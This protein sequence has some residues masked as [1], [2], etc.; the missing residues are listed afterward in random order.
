[1]VKRGRRRR[2]SSRNYLPGLQQELVSPQQ[3]FALLVAKDVPLGSA[4]IWAQYGDAADTKIVAQVIDSKE[5][6]QTGAFVPAHRRENWRFVVPPSAVD[7]YA[8][9][10]QASL[11]TK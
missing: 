3:L 1:M 5:K 6:I 9:F 4:K 10:L 7:K 2:P 8:A 11:E